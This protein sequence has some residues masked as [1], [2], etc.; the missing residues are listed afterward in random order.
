MPDYHSQLEADVAKRITDFFAE[1]QIGAKYGLLYEPLLTEF[2]P[3]IRS[4][5]R[6]DFI[7]MKGPY[8][9]MIIEVVSPQRLHS[10]NAYANISE[11]MLSLELLEADH[12][13]LTDGQL[14]HIMEPNGESE[15]KKFESLFSFF[16]LSLTPEEITGITQTIAGTISN[17][18]K[19]FEA[20][21]DTEDL[22]LLRIREFLDSNFSGARIAYDADGRFFHFSESAEGGID[23]FED[24]FFQY[25]LRP[26]ADNKV[27]RY[28]TLSTVFHTITGRSYR[29]ASHLAMNDRGEVDYVD[30]YIDDSY[31]TLPNLSLTEM[32]QLNNSYISSLTSIEQRDDLTMYRLYA[33]ETKGVCMIFK[34]KNNLTAGNLILR[35]ISYARKGGYH[36]ELE[37]LRRIVK[38]L[39]TLKIRFKFRKLELWKHFFKSADY[40]IEQEVRMLYID[41]NSLPADKKGWVIANPDSII[42]K[43]ILLDIQAKNF[44]LELSELILAP[45]C[46]EKTL[47]KKQFEVLSAERGFHT[48]VHISAIESFR[49]S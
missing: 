39:K 5:F 4:R 19:P 36:P 18:F 26:V 14:I 46:P 17:I 21:P 48:A 30:R 27:C 1:R 40:A 42:S 2:N 12:F 22:E 11:Y 15:L 9:F 8:V 38:R 34:I 16:D 47:N 44:P 43:Y 10:R 32:Q 37:L 45:N 7:V 31:T 24:Q 35:Q 49:K 13:I 6:P 23:G 20:V 3:Q 33:E 28:T 29:M 41:D 25:L